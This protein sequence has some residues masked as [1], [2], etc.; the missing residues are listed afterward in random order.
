MPQI[1]HWICFAQLRHLEKGNTLEPGLL[2]LFFALYCA[3]TKWQLWFPKGDIGAQ[4]K[5]LHKT[6][7]PIRKS[8]YFPALEVAMV[9]VLTFAT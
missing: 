2:C 5:C 6:Y 4:A 3:G 7:F 1:G 9:L 8:A